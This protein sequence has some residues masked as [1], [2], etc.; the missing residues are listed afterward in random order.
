MT[1]VSLAGEMAAGKGERMV[2]Q[3]VVQT[4]IATVIPRETKMV[5]LMVVWMVSMQAWRWGQKTVASMGV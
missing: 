2:G 4:D 1:V 3:L 5:A